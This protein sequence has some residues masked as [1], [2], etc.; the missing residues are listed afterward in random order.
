MARRRMT[1]QERTRQIY[2]RVCFVCALVA[3][4]FTVLYVFLNDA[5]KTEIDL[6][7]VTHIT[8]TGFDGE[9]VL[10]ATIDVDEKYG[11][12]YQT[13]S[14]DFSKSSGL[15]NGDEVTISFNYD[16]SVAKNYNLK[17]KA[18]DMHYTV[19]GLVAATPVSENDLFEGLDINFE[20]IAPLATA[21]L[22]TSNTK[23]K[24]VVTYQ[25]IDE[26]E[27]YDAGET[28]RVRAVFDEAD[29]EE[30]DYKATTPSEECIKEYIVE[31]VDRY[32]T[33]T[34][35]ITD[36]MMASLKKEALTLFTDANEYGMRIFCDAGLMPVYVNKQTTFKWSSPN[37]I[38][39]YL[40]V[41][42]EESYGKTGTHVN[43][44]KLCYESVISQADGKA[45]KAEVIVRF[46][47]I[48]IRKDG[49]IDL[50]LESGEIISADRRDS[51]IKAIVRNEIDK[52]Y[53]SVKLAV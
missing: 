27:Y 3:V 48:I 40:N 51:H 24:D 23:F 41:L 52:D 32:I 44:I 49:T 29:L 47:D 12:F 39:S 30:L 7:E 19:N 13:V 1:K 21:S 50:K 33:D 2:L 17:V 10:S 18:N 38:S 37:Y 42:R 53:E 35:Q 43:D 36:E 8:L 9:G 14:V 6:K 15:T 5:S 26:K 20:G 4:L 34:D 31:D 46:Q 11:A 28:I 25:I 16:K 22:D 45:C